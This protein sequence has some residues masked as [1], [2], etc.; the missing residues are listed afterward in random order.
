MEI[1]IM[2]KIIFLLLEVFL[3]PAVWESTDNAHLCPA[4]HSWHEKWSNFI[5]TS[6]P[7]NLCQVW[8]SLCI[9][10]VLVY[11][12]W[13]S[14]LENSSAACSKLWPWGSGSLWARTFSRSMSGKG[15]DWNSGR[16]IPTPTLW[17]FKIQKLLEIGNSNLF[18]DHQEKK[19]S[20]YCSVLQ[21]VC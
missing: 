5:T 14:M 17:A 4:L 2:K 10:K 12:S 7:E 21:S 1:G 6:A 16:V 11:R 18:K 20:K 13:G 15:S 19:R 9:R 3:T 8:C